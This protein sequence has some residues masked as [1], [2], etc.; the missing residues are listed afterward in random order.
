[1]VAWVLGLGYCRVLGAGCD[2]LGKSCSVSVR[3]LARAS[4]SLFG[5]LGSLEVGHAPVDFGFCRV[6]GGNWLGLS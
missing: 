3:S 1:M 4:L 2:W 5:G 6:D